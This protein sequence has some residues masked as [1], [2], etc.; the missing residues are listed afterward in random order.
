MLMDVLSNMLMSNMLT[1]VMVVYV[2][3][4]QLEPLLSCT[5]D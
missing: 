2:I 3:L 4:I 5:S 1:V